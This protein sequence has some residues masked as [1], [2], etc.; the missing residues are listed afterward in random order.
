MVWFI[1]IFG[2]LSFPTSTTVF[3][4]HERDRTELRFVKKCGKIPRVNF[5]RIYLFI[6]LFI[7]S[8]IAFNTSITQI[9][10][11]QQQQYKPDKERKGY[12]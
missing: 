3:T 7:N 8:G 12:K 1:I 10:G 11:S 4:A 5:D 6:Y 2:K 9:Q